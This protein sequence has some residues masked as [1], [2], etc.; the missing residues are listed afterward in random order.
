MGWNVTAIELTTKYTASTVPP[1]DP[2][3]IPTLAGVTLRGITGTGTG[4]VYS[5]TGPLRGLAFDGVMLTGS[6]GT[7]M[8]APGASLMRTTLTGVP[9]NATVLPC[10]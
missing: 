10:D 5:I 6:A 8:Q 2:T 3:L 4:P 1:H 9:S 7:C